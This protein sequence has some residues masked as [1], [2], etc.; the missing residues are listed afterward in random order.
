M[1]PLV[2][3]VIVLD[4]TGAR[5]NIRLGKLIGQGGAG[6][7]Y[8]SPDLADSVVKIY[9]PSTNPKD[10][11]TYAR[12]LKAMLDVP[13]SLVDLGGDGQP[14]NRFRSSERF[15][16]IAWPT[17]VVLDRGGR[18]L[19]YVMPS[20]ATGDTASL[21]EAMDERDAQ[22]LGIPMGL[23]QRVTLGCQLAKVIAELHLSG[24]YLV[25]LKPSNL[26]FYKKPLFMAI[27]DC[28]GF[29]IRG[30][31]ER[32]GAPQHTPDYLAP[33]FQV[34]GDPN[35]NPEAQDRFGL[36]VIIFRLLNLGI[37][38][39]SGRPLDNQVPNELQEKIADRLYAY[40]LNPHPRLAPQVLS[41][42]D[43]IPVELRNMFD[44][45]F[46]GR[47]IQRPSAAGWAA[48][49]ETYSRRQNGHI[50][51][52]SANHEHW[53]FSGMPCGT[54]RQSEVR[55][56]LLT[57]PKPTRGRPRKTARPL[58]VAKATA[59]RAPLGKARVPKAP[60]AQASPARQS[61]KK[62]MPTTN[63]VT[64]I[65]PCTKCGEPYDSAEPSRNFCDKC[66][67][68]LPGATG[69]TIRGILG[70]PRRQGG[71]P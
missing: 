26:N 11:E 14:Y 23:G 32:L 7:I 20:V 51:Q 19:G 29:S 63:P 30:R 25:D 2:S 36:G 12:K 55:N 48:V 16:Q 43:C 5:R 56:A 70:T 57:P 52:C 34:A 27:L 64:T 44:K 31:S 50:Q 38:P 35:T 53:H 21:E 67:A 1:N 10:L 45:A 4:A 69:R 47:P 71:T 49:L 24:H 42:H 54:C 65:V 59:A 62:T 46:T 13:P 66:G 9:A 22:R 61:A 37:H 58:P 8:L 6:A 18:F 40:G 33:E 41:I 60:A 3:D 68:Q 39:F 15:V 17:G 28:D